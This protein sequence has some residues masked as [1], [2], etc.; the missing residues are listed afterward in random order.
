MSCCIVQTT[1][2]G[3]LETLKT[4]AKHSSS[5]VQRLKIIDGTG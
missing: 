4:Q 3:G 1:V 5:H 2:V